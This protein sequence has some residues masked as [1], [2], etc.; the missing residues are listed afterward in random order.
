M[1]GTEKSR[2]RLPDFA[3]GEVLHGSG[4]HRPVEG[5]TDPAPPFVR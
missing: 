5:R 2:R 1:N 3:L 4:G